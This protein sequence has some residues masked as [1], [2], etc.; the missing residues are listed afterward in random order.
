MFIRLSNIFPTCLMRSV[1]SVFLC[2]A[3]IS[4]MGL[5]TAFSH[6]DEQEKTK[7][8]VSI[9]EKININKAN[10]EQLAS[11]LIG[12]GAKK[13]EAIVSWRQKNGKFKS[14]EQL[15]EVKGI[16]DVLIGKNRNKISI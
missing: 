13:A 14:I 9:N 16:G 7:S 2:F 15:S 10:A 1:S 8:L 12:V 4:I 5:P 3:M 11:T 6:A